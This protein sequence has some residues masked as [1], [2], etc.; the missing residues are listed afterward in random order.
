MKVKEEIM[1]A[2]TRDDLIEIESKTMEHFR[3]NYYKQLLKSDEVKK[4]I[5]EMFNVDEH[6]IQNA[7]M[8]NGYPPLDDFIDD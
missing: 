8:I 7:L 6:V 4:H 3:S 2:N 1:N 5:C